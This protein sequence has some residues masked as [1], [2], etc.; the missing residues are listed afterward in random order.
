MQF[1]F[2]VSGSVED[3]R[4]ESEGI[5]SLEMGF[6]RHIFILFLSLA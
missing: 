3:A 2:Q 5:G 6:K 4:G 1:Q